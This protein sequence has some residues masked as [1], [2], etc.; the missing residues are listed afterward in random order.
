MKPL[1]TTL[2]FNT[3]NGVR[4]S[5]TGLNIKT[6]V[7]GSTMMHLLENCPLALSVGEEVNKGYAFVWTPTMKPYFAEAKIVT[8]RCPKS[9][10]YEAASL[11]EIKRPPLLCETR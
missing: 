4:R 10:R 5:N 2:R 7:A 9:R 8:V 3:A 11:R 1:E 6:Q